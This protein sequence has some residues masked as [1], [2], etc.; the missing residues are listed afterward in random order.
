MQDSQ[1][2]YE[3]FDCFLN[4]HGARMEEEIFMNFMNQYLNNPCCCSSL[5]L[6]VKKKSVL[7]L[8]MPY[9]QTQINDSDL[10]NIVDSPPVIRG[11]LKKTSAAAGPSLI[12]TSDVKINFLLNK[13][14][15]MFF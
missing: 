5:L 4:V 2:Q 11:L 3:D 12:A 15:A 1:V 10:L 8:D 6:R 9:F 14:I 7:N 13:F